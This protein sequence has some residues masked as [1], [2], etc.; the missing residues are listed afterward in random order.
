MTHDDKHACHVNMDYANTQINSLACLILICKVLNECVNVICVCHR[1]TSWWHVMTCKILYLTMTYVRILLILGIYAWL[2]RRYW[3]LCSLCEVS[4][5]SSICI[6]LCMG[7]QIWRKL[8][9]KNTLGFVS[10]FFKHNFCQIWLP[11]HG[12]YRLS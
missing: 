8:C 4:I 2:K 1:Q 5:A 12:R 10:V 6:H 7:S 11:S 9:L 3:Y